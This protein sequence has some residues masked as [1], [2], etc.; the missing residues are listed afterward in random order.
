MSHI[1]IYE[2]VCVYV[3]VYA[4]KRSNKKFSVTLSVRADPH[5]KGVI[6]FI[7]LESN[8]S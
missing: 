7:F 1:Y 6:C 4:Y 2:C 8:P 3:C 5:E